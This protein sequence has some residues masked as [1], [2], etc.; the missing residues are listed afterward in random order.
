M[1]LLSIGLLS[2]EARALEPVPAWWH[3]Q[4]TL[5]TGV[6]F[7]T[8]D[9]GL[10]IDTDLVYVPFTLTYL[11]DDFA[12]TD[13]PWDQL[14][15]R[16]TIP[17]LRIDG[18]ADFFSGEQPTES[19][20]D[21]GIGD[22]LLRLGYIWIPLRDS[23]LPVLELKGL[24][25]IPT[26]SAE[27]DLGTGAPDFQLSVDLSKSFGPVSPFATAGYRFVG[28]RKALG[29][30]SFALTSVG[31]SAWLHDRFSLG[32]AYDWH[33]SSAVSRVDSHELV[34]FATIR[35]PRGFTLGP[36]ATFGLAGYT[37]DYGGGLSIRY[38]FALRGNAPPFWR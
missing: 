38:S 6:D 1:L 5:S 14:E 21:N 37:P 16:L 20:V 4:L 29:L 28:N 27:K 8:G 34:P 30:K 17:F 35:L 10:P 19:R 18:P 7:S 32:L 36:Y 2:R 9:Y 22:I 33:G 3:G 11:S 12:L 31:L 15:L 26:A 25:K 13:H 23:K 24:V